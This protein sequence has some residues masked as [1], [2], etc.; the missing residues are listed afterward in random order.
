[1]TMQPDELREL[2]KSLNW[3]QADMATAMG[4]SRKAVNEMEGREDPIDRRTELAALFLAGSLGRPSPLLVERGATAAWEELLS[5]SGPHLR[6]DADDNQVIGTV[7]MDA[8]AQA[9]FR[10]MNAALSEQP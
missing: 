4:I 3:T 8:V 2:R 9:V 6:I 10:A 5:Q 1:M 7:D